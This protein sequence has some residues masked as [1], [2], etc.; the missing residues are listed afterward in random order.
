M[1]KIVL[2]LLALVLCASMMAQSNT[3][4]VSEDALAMKATRMT[5]YLK[6]LL[7]LDQTQYQEV[8]DIQM[9]VQRKFVV[10]APYKNSDPE[11]FHDKQLALAKDTDARLLK[12]LNEPQQALYKQK[13]AERDVEQARRDRLRQ[14]S[15]KTN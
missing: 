7:E 6:G 1:K 14:S 4:T 8:Y 15:N 10:L 2:G 5:N 9:D 11:L 12:V 3:Y 13:I